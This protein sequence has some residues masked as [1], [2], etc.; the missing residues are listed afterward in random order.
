VPQSGVRGAAK[1]VNTAFLLMFYYIRYLQIV[2]FNQLGV[3]P[4]LFNELK[5]AANQKRLKSTTIKVS[6]QNFKILQ[7]IAHEKQTVDKYI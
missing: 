7:L 6:I 1:F 4:I 2:I 3:P 5:G